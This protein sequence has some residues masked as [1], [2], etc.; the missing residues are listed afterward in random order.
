MLSQGSVEEAWKSPD[1]TESPK[2]FGTE[3]ELRTAVATLEAAIHK[4][5]P[6][7][8]AFTAVQLFLVSINF[9]D[10]ELSGHKT[11]L[12]FLSNFVDEILRANARNW[13]EKKKFVSNQE[14]CA[15][16]SANLTRKGVTPKGGGGRGG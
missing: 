4:V 8:F 9:G 2:E 6:W 12:Q 14:L 13:E 1:K 16:W 11:R 3:A 5:M 7:N 15:R 10:S